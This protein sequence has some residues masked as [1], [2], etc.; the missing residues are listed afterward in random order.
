[1]SDSIGKLN[2]EGGRDLT[3]S[4]WPYFMEDFK[5]DALCKDNFVGHVQEVIADTF[6][7]GSKTY[8]FASE[9][10]EPM[11]VF[12]EAAEYWLNGRKMSSLPRVSVFQFKQDPTMIVTT[13]SENRLERAHMLDPVS[14]AP[15]SL[16]PSRPGSS[17]FVTVKQVR[18]PSLSLF[19]SWPI[20]HACPA[21]YPSSIGVYRATLTMKNWLNLK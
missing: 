18:F 12:S 20:L 21:A 13:N 4:E 15:V 10:L 1:M 2:D 3:I 14:G 16:I 17:T 8:S 11:N 19:F 5:E 7:V 6:D 9:N